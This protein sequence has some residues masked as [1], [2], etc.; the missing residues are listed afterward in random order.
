[1]RGDGG[2]RSRN[3]TVLGIDCLFHNRSKLPYFLVE[4]DATYF[5]SHRYLNVVQVLFFVFKHN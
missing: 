2:R 1:M 5:H 3:F 4:S